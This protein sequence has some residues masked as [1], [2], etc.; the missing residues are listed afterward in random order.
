MSLIEYLVYAL[1][2]LSLCLLILVTVEQ[3]RLMSEQVGG[4]QPKG[5]GKK[6][7]PKKGVVKSQKGPKSQKLSSSTLEAMVRQLF[8]EPPEPT[9][10]SRASQAMVAVI[11]QSARGLF[12]LLAEEKWA[13]I[14]KRIVGAGKDCPRCGGKQTQQSK[15]PHYRQYYSR[16]IC[17]ACQEKGQTATFYELS[18]S[19]FEGSHLS[20]RRWLWG[21]FLFVSGCSTREMATELQIN[22]K[23]AQRMAALLQLTLI[24]SRYRFSL[25]GPVEFDEIYIIGGLKGRA[26]KLDL[27]RPPRNAVCAG[28]AG[29][30]GKV[31]KCPSW[32]WLAATETSIWCPVPMFRVTPFDP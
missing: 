19:I 1:L 20:P 32:A 26:G 29:G 23:T 8:P 21:L 30:S 28:Q 17:R 4:R 11:K 9:E 6:P 22:L 7:R 10:R 12:E 5:V 27:D 14:L 31:I 24:T 2:H 13:H 16:R 25:T 18:G 15:D 3:Q